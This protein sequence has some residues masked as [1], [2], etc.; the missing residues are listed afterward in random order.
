[1]PRKST[2][3]KDRRITIRISENDLAKLEGAARK[4]EQTVGAV[5]RSLIRENLTGEEEQPQRPTEQ[6]G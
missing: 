3:Q 4:R 5:V 6:Q 1:M 2:D